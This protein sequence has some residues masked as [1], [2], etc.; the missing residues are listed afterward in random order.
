VEEKLNEIGVS[1]KELHKR[2]W[3][4]WLQC[5]ANHLDLFTEQGSWSFERI[6]QLMVRELLILVLATLFVCTNSFWDHCELLYYF[7]R[8]LWPHWSGYINTVH[9]HGI[10]TRYINTHNNRSE[11]HKNSQQSHK[12]SFHEINVGAWSAVTSQLKR[13]LSS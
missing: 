5:M 3:H 1:Y 12:L 11:I 8:E 10:S 9:Q 7:Y 4:V 2:F 6:K 13:G